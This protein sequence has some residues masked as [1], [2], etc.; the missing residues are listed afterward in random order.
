MSKRIIRVHYYDKSSQ[1]IACK[2]QNYY[3]ALVQTTETSSVTCKNCLNT[4]SYRKRSPIYVHVPT[5]PTKTLEGRKLT[6]VQRFKIH[7]K[8]R[9]LI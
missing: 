4:G 8:N 5:I 7:F 6:E 1:N 3:G 2:A 9:G